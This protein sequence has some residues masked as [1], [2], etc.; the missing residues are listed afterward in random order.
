MEERRG[1]FSRYLEAVYHLYSRTPNM[2]RWGSNADAESREGARLPSLTPISSSAEFQER[3][4]FD[5]YGV[6]FE[7]HRIWTH[8]NVG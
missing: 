5:L 3:E 1:V 7:G 6:H 2:D 4:I 8:S